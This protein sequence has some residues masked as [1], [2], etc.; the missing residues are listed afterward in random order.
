[1][2]DRHLHPDD[3][4]T[5]ELVVTKAELTMAR[6]VDGRF[7]L[8]VRNGAFATMVVVYAVLT[9]V[10]VWLRTRLIPQGWQVAA[11]CALVAVLAWVCP[12]LSWLSGKKPPGWAASAE[13]CE[14][15][16]MTGFRPRP[17]TLFP[18]SSTGSGGGTA[19]AGTRCMC[20]CPGAPALSRRMRVSARPPGWYR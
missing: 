19:V 1:M 5:A 18:G 11:A 15:A 4:A 17:W 3:G 14:R 12:W 13:T 16:W 20:T 9:I 7:E 2:T 10:G 6:R 8:A